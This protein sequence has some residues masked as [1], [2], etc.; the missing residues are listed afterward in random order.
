M[1]R[2]E[3]LFTPEQNNALVNLMTITGDKSY[4]D[5]V[6]RLIAQEAAAQDIEWPDNMPAAKTLKEAR[7]KRWPKD[8]R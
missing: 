6:R 8:E 7:A 1:I 4:A 5:L 3:M 2:K